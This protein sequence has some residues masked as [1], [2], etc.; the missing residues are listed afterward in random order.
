MLQFIS[1][2]LRVAF[3]ATLQLRSVRGAA[4]S[5]Q[6]RK[7][8]GCGLSVC[9]STDLKMV[10]V[11]LSLCP[12]YAFFPLVWESQTS[13]EYR[14]PQSVQESITEGG[15]VCFIETPALERNDRIPPSCVN[16]MGQNFAM[17]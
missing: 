14:L 6:E 2:A 11:S 12:F 3:S 8:A 10:L 15:C 7:P 4:N 13:T 17:A 1:L 9:P 16:L 5:P